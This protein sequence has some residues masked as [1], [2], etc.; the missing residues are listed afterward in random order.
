MAIRALV[1]VRGDSEGEEDG[2]GP[3]T[4]LTMGIPVILQDAFLA[5]TRLPGGVQY[6]AD[7]LVHD[8]VLFLRRE[9]PREAPELEAKKEVAC[10]RASETHELCEWAVAMSREVT[11]AVLEAHVLIYGF[12][13]VSLAICRSLRGCLAPALGSGG[14]RAR[15]SSWSFPLLGVWRDWGLTER[16]PCQCCG[17]AEGEVPQGGASVGACEAGACEMRNCFLLWSVFF[18]RLGGHKQCCVLI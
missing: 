7:P 16:G 14:E 5:V 8:G 1:G 11:L 4:A 12:R 2:R 9:A 17:C 10:R 18:V 13:E 15:I 3:G 6:R